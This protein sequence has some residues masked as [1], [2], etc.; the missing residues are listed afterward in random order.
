MNRIRT[1]VQ[2]SAVSRTGRG[3]AA[4]AGPRSGHADD[5]VTI[6]LP[7]FLRYSGAGRLFDADASKDSVL[8]A[9]LVFQTADSAPAVTTHY[10]TL[11]SDWKDCPVNTRSGGTALGFASPDR[12]QTVMFTVKSAAAGKTPVSVYYSGKETPK[13]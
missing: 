6:G 1:L 3:A 11:L 10:K 9:T 2:L 12:R 7:G 4:K 5:G 8:K 13:P